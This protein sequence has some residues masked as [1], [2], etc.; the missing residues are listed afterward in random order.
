MPA[1]PLPSGC[2]V[3]CSSLL[4]LKTYAPHRKLSRVSVL[5]LVVVALDTDLDDDG[6]HGVMG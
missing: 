3:Y 2:N 6:R 5:V 1:V 4:R